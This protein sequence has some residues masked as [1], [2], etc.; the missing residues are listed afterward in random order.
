MTHVYQLPAAYAVT[1]RIGAR[2][3]E[4][5]WRPHAPTGE[6]ACRLLPAYRIARDHFLG[7]LGLDVLVIER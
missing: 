4:T 6:T 5:E 7:S 2:G 3:L 1:F